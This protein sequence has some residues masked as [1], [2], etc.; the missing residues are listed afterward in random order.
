MPVVSEMLY[1]IRSKVCLQNGHSLPQ[2]SLKIQQW[3]LQTISIYVSLFNNQKQN[4]VPL[5]KNWPR[6]V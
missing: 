3:L 1:V 4:T 2:H 6:F 5:K